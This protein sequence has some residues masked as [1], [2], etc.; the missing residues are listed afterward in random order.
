ML[1]W[2]PNHDILAEDA[3]VQ[4]LDKEGNIVR[5]EP[6]DRYDHKIFRGWSWVQSDDGSWDRVGWARVA[7]RQDG[8]HPL[9]EGAFTIMHDHHHILLRST[10]METKQELDPNLE[11]TT[12]EYM[13]VFRD[14]DIGRQVD[15][16]L[17]R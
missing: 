17:R 5:T 12:E 8:L 4:F 11:D 13:V 14:S 16:D 1:T 7:V 6:I 10:Y 9:F 3:H 15:L 2:A